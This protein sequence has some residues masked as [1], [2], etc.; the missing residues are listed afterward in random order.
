M[1]PHRKFL[2]G[3][4]IPSLVVP[5]LKKPVFTGNSLLRENADKLMQE[6][7]TVV[8]SLR[9]LQ[10]DSVVLSGV[11][12]LLNDAVIRISEFGDITDMNASAE[13]M[14]QYASKDVIGKSPE[15]VLGIPF[16][17][18]VSCAEKGTPFEASLLKCNDE[19]LDASISVT[20]IRHLNIQD[21]MEYIV[22]IRDI[23]DILKMRQ[24]LSETD[25]KFSALFKALDEASDVIMLTD[26]KNEIIFVNSAFTKH[27]GYTFDEAVGRNPGFYKSGDMHEAF[28]DDL[29]EHMRSRRVWSGTLLN[30]SKSGNLLYDR[31]IITPVMNGDPTQPSYYIAVKQL[32]QSA[33][34]CDKQID[35]DLDK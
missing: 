20:S 26:K 23:T 4:A 9:E 24:A 6:I 31:T 32:N 5:D 25:V 11:Y 35:L 2:G 28:Y 13:R 21:G 10:K 19:Y 12:S 29:W 18:L 7:N 22:I 14:F 3:S 27:T 16:R 1:K 33:V 15:L 17:R 30:R 8:D 34:L